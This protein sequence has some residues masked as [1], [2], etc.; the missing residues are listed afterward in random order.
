MKAAGVITAAFYLTVESNG[1]AD[2]SDR[3]QELKKILLLVQLDELIYP[4]ET[5]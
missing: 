4:Q 1:A 3:Y 5:L 2:A